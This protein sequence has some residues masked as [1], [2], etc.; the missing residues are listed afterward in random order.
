MTPDVSRTLDHL[1]AF[2]G[3]AHAMVSK[4]EAQALL[5]STDGDVFANGRL[6][7][8]VVASRGAGMYDVRLK[9]KEYGQW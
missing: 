2:P 5:K 7:D 8:L 3:V 1:A 4:A 6:Y 9:L